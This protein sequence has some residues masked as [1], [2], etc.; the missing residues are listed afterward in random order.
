MYQPVIG[1]F[2]RFIK[3][4]M[5]QK[6]LNKFLYQPYSMYA[7]MRKHCPVFWSEHFKHW[8]FF[9]YDTVKI[10]LSDNQT[11]SSQSVETFN[12]L[13]DFREEMSPFYEIM[14]RWMVLKDDPEHR[15]LRNIMAKMFTPASVALRAD[16]TKQLAQS[17]IDEMKKKEVVDLAA[18]FALPLPASV[19]LDIFGIEE[20]NF[21]VVEGWVRKIAVVVGRTRDPKALKDGQEALLKMKA[22]LL[23]KIEASEVKEGSLLYILIKGKKENKITEQDLIANSIMLLS[24]GFGTIEATILGGMTALLKDKQQFTLLKENPELMDL[25]IEE[26]LRF[27]SPAQ[28]PTRVTTKDVKIN[29]VWIKK[30]QGVAPIVGSA[31]RDE[32]IFKNADKLDITRK[33]NPHLAMGIGKHHCIGTSLL[34]L[35]GPIAFSLLLNTFPNMELLDEREDWNTDNFSFR[36]LK[37]LRVRLNP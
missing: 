21:T 33:N 13:D 16:R 23:N 37:S 10:I 29:G 36:T 32:R 14:E 4:K 20:S 35:Q 1:N 3:M 7:K 11:F 9:D 15:I 19:F 22:Y 12:L 5:P 8:L 25:A 34:D 27:T 30:G 18:D 24:G 17:L 31:N 6:S 2:S 26:I 28:A